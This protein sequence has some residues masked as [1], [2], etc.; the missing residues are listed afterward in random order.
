M[1]SKRMPPSARGQCG[2][3]QS[4]VTALDRFPYWRRLAVRGKFICCGS[5]RHEPGSKKNRM[6]TKR[7]KGL[8]PSRSST[9]ELICQ[10]LEF[11]RKDKLHDPMELEDLPG[12]RDRESRF[13]SVLPLSPINVSRWKKR[14]LCPPPPLLLR[15]Y[16]WL[17]DT[18]DVIELI[19]KVNEMIHCFGHG[20][21]SKESVDP[22]VN[23]LSDRKSTSKC[24]PY[25]S[26][27]NSG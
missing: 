14:G 26:H 25:L 18:W 16:P 5:G 13:N 17:F 15:G 6:T 21:S 3:Y 11:K 27:C 24:N 2:I 7:S 10:P 4:A 22:T 19:V 9:A 1:Q 8:Y 12:D 20:V 23:R